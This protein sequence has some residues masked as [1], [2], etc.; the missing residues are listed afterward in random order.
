MSGEG[1]GASGEWRVGRGAQLCAR[2]GEWQEVTAEFPNFTTYPLLYKTG[3]L[4]RYLPSGNLEYLGRLDRQ[5]KIRGYR[6]ELGEI[7][8]LLSQHPD[9]K[10]AIVVAP[11]DELGNHRLVAYIVF[12]PKSRHFLHLG[13]HPCA[14]V[15]RVE[16]S[17]VRPQ[18]QSGSKIYGSKMVSPRS[19]VLIRILRFG[20]FFGWRTRLNGE[21]A[22]ACQI[23]CS[24]FSF[25]F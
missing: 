15:P 22:F 21:L 5:V 18:D 23:L 13:S 12:N 8:S 11:K 24:H 25:N 6:I 14:R 17:G 1:R 20:N 16:G 7:E 9:V 10:E 3:D 19:L 4:V 2:T